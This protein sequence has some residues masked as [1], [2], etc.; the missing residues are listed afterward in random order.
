M[1]EVPSGGLTVVVL[2][3][4]SGNVGR[5]ETGVCVIFGI[6]AA[7]KPR[8]ER[9]PDYG[10]THH[11]QKIVFTNHLL[12]SLHQCVNLCLTLSGK[13]QVIT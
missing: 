5:E 3:A 13:G 2:K 9:K 10:P 4:E 12:Q 11:G 8:L 7:G 6:G 1:N